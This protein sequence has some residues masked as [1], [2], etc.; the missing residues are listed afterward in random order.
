MTTDDDLT[1]QIARA[2]RAHD[3]TTHG[4]N[5]T[6]RLTVEVRDYL[7]AAAAVLP[8]IRK[9]ERDAAREALNG[10][11]RAEADMYLTRCQRED[12]RGAAWCGHARQ[13][14]EEYRDTHYPEETP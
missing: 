12:Y 8:I 2:L 1:K 6:M 7:P 4:W 10:L 14:A 9:A 11:A 3:A 13:V 5:G